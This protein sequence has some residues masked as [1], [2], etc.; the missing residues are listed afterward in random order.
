MY[1]L[2]IDAFILY[3]VFLGK[4]YHRSQKSSFQKD[5]NNISSNCIRM[6]TPNWQL[7]SEKVGYAAIGA[8]FAYEYKGKIH[9]EK[10]NEISL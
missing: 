2:Q 8:L 4:N 3:I 9:F 5:L 10:L 7:V 6:G 1:N